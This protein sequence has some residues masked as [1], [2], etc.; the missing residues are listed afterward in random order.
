VKF[1]DDLIAAGITPLVTLYHWDA[2][3]ALDEKYGGPLGNQDEWVKDFARYAR[4]VFEAM[5]DRV[6]YWITFNEPYVLF[7]WFLAHFRGGLC[8]ARGQS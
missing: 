4:V 1:V 8:H 3:Q 2:P 5:G 6:K 7:L